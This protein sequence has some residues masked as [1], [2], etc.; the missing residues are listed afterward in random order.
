MSIRAV[1]G[2][3]TY[4]DLTD[5]LVCR[6]GDHVFATA[7]H[8]VLLQS[9]SGVFGCTLFELALAALELKAV[10]GKQ[11]DLELSEN[12]ISQ[13]GVLVLLDLLLDGLNFLSLFQGRVAGLGPAKR[14]FLVGGGRA[15]NLSGE[16]LGLNRSNAWVF[17]ERWEGIIGAEVC[18][19]LG[20]TVLI[21]RLVDFLE[22]L[23]K[24]LT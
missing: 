8:G 14:L 19:V 16:R 6:R 12:V 21:L 7:K 11:T 10:A 18:E 2:L 22:C 13:L 23:D 1:V 4:D 15:W 3:E 24:L 9:G 17:E 5:L 20:L